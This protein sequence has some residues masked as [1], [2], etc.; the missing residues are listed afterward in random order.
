LTG[1]PWNL[2][3]ALW[4][5]FPF[6]DFGL[7]FL[8]V[9]A[10]IGIYGLSLLTILGATF[11]TYSKR[12]CVSVVILFLI[13]SAA[14]FIRLTHI[15]TV[16]TGINI[17]LIQPSI[18]QNLKWAPDQ[19][20]RNLDLQISL[21]NLESERPLQAIIWPEAS[22]SFL[23]HSSPELVTYLG[24]LTQPNGYMI[25]G[26]P[27]KDQDQLFNSLH[28][29]N[30]DGQIEKS[31]DKVHLLPFG[32]YMPFKSILPFE[33]ITT[34]SVDFSPGKG[35]DSIYVSNIPSFSPL[36]CYEAVYSG[37]VT[38]PHQRPEW[39]LNLTNDG[40]FGFTSGPYQHFALVRLRAIEEGLPLVRV[41]NN[42]ISAVVDSLGRVLH[43]LDLDDVG[44]IDFDL[45]SPRPATFFS[46]HKNTIYWF[47]IATL[48]A[49]LC[50]RLVMYSTSCKRSESI[51]V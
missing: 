44:F 3:G 30:H 10:W 15:P 2:S 26:G 16:L 12:S 37:H 14:G 36:I 28:V 4:G 9:C 11:F 17:R 40:W 27:R 7:S 49:V 6:Y 24:Q 46:T 34:G 33:K 39:L 19:Q 47:M 13:L 45:P 50:Y 23:I 42:G 20:K 51:C 41:A 25:I 1:F 38:P 18:A 48:L 29:I 21:S 35:F 32:E 22:I 8:Q 43:R 5:A 31:Y